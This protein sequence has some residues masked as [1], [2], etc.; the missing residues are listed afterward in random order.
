MSAEDLQAAGLEKLDIVS[1]AEGKD[2]DHLPLVVDFVFR[3]G[4][5]APSRP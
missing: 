2:Y 4:G 3:S 1:D 5:G